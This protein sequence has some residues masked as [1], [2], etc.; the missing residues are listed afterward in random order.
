MN[1]KPIV[2]DILSCPTHLQQNVKQ[3]WIYNH[4]NKYV[5]W[6]TH[7]G[8][9][10]HL[11][12]SKL[13]IIGSDNGLPPDRRQAII[14]TI[15]R[16][17]LIGPLETNFSEILTEIHTF[18]FRKKHLKMSSGKWQPFCLSLNVLNVMNYK[19]TVKDIL[20]CPTH[21]QQNVKQWWI[22]SHGKR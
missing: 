12:I 7:W 4:E 3:Q 11:C 5:M 17:L 18:S 13:N 2:L 15:A 19:P 9:V 20:S 22:Y 8:R 6:L 16:I 1:Y 14:W 21:L 10:M